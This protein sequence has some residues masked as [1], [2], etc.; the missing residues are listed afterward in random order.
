MLLASDRGRAHQVPAVVCQFVAL[1]VLYSQ[2][3]DA[4]RLVRTCDACSPLTGI[5]NDLLFVHA[6]QAAIIQ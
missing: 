4:S 5:G 6:R 1:T 2:T 3:P